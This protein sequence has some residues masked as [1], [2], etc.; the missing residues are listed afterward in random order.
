MMPN[1]NM[2]FTFSSGVFV[3]KNV[4]IGLENKRS[5]VEIK[6]LSVVTQHAEI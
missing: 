3:Q 5:Y 1:Y 6:P 4:K 2:Y